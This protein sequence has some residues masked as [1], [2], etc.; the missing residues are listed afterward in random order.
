MRD[1]RSGTGTSAPRIAFTSSPAPPARVAAAALGQAYGSVPFGEADVIVA[2]GGDG[3]MIDALHRILALPPAVPRPPVFG[4]NRGTAGFLM[5]DFASDG[6]HQR[7]Q[8]AVSTTIVPLRMRAH[9]LE[10]RPLPDVLACNEVALRRLHGQ[11]AR[12]RVAVDGAVRV[13]ELVGDGVLVATPAGS[14]AYNR[15]A[16]GPIIPLGTGLLALTP[17]C[18]MRP[19]GWTG[20]L[21]PHRSVVR[22]E[23]LSGATRPVAATADQRELVPVGAVEV[24]EADDE[25]RLLFDSGSAL[26]QRLL[27]EQFAF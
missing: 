4:M 11:S 19:R 8:Q 14:T 7:I 9:D 24:A 1:R 15:S 22:I 27:A 3:A 18:P 5:N 23:V 25:L 13:P 12:L 20:A 17:I 10:G 6:L 16:H 26:D 21:L 2:V